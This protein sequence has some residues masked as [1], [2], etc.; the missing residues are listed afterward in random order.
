[1]PTRFNVDSAACS[2]KSWPPVTLASAWPHARSGCRR[3]YRQEI[4]VS[5]VKSS[6][7]VLSRDLF[8]CDSSL[9]SVE[10]I[11][12]NFQYFFNSKSNFNPFSSQMWKMSPFEELVPRK[13]FVNYFTFGSGCTVDLPWPKKKKTATWI[14]TKIRTLFLSWNIENQAWSRFHAAIRE[15]APPWYCVIWTVF[16]FMHN[17]SGCFIFC[18]GSTCTC[19][20]K[21]VHT[22]R[23]KRENKASSFFRK[24]IACIHHAVSA[25]FFLCTK[26]LGPLPEHSHPWIALRI[27]IATAHSWGIRNQSAWSSG[28]SL[29]S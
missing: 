16:W 14:M 12:E 22:H 19:I 15:A 2:A 25:L 1:M 21:Y 28:I 5:I 18:P 26:N 13:K 17:S 6:C 9:F 10:L 27:V 11:N 23:L 7:D 4:R 24:S 8:L 3:P 20:N 29:P